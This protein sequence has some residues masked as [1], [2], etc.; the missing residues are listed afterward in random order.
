[1]RDSLKRYLSP[2][3]AAF[4]VFVLYVVLATAYS[5][6]N[7]IFESPDE[8]LHY[9]YVRTLIETR[10]LPVQQDGVQSEA[11][12]PPLYYVLNALVAGFIPV[13]DYQ[14]AANP[15]WAYDAYRVG[16]DNKNLYLH[17]DT[18][19]FPYHATSLAVHVMRW[20]S[21]ALG[22]L[23]L[24]VA[25]RLLKD[26]FVDRPIIV[27]GVL[28][29]ATFNPQFLFITSSINNDN[30]VT[31][32]GTLVLWWSVRS[33][34]S[35]LATRG[36]VIG[37][38]LLGA[39]LLTKLSAGALLLVML[40][41][42]V[43]APATWRERLKSVVVILLIA[44]L[45][46]GWWFVRNMQLY[47]EPTGV[48]TMLSIWGQRQVLPGF[49]ETQAQVLGLWQSFWGKFGYG[50]IVL[51]DLLYSVLALIGVA[52]LIGW[53]MVAFRQRRSNLNRRDGLVLLS[54]LLA[55]LI[56]LVVFG[57]SN[58]SG[59]HGRL[60][61][62][63]I[64]PIAVFLFLG[65]RY[66]LR[67]D[68]HRLDVLVAVVSAAS[69]LVLSIVALFTYLIPA[70]AKPELLDIAQVRDRTKPLHVRYG[71]QALL[72]GYH[73]NRNR[74]RVGDAFR[75]TLCWQALATTDTNYFQSVHLLRLEDETI[76]ARR[77]SYTGLG[78]FPSSQWSRGDV[79]CDMLRMPV[80]DWT[81]S[82]AVYD[83]RVGLTNYETRERLSSVSS[84]GQPLELVLVDRIKV[85]PREPIAVAIDAGVNATVDD[86]MRLLDAR[87][88]P[89][90]VSRGGTASLKLVWQALRVP[91]AD[92]TV[93][94]HV[95]DA[96]GTQVAQGDSQPLD[97]RYPTSFW[98]ADEVVIDTHRIEVP[99][100]LP[101]GA[102]DV[103]VGVYLLET[104]ERLPIED[105]LDAS[106]YVA[107]L[108]VQP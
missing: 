88:N 21:I 34:R 91:D 63:A 29:V 55:L 83:L 10:Q 20:L 49:E 61:F 40:V 80:E 68:A 67:S 9:E 69:L 60:L 106:V 108:T 101:P 59:I 74:V 52:S 72:L 7:P 16:D 62:P 92:Y 75:V 57:R 42:I 87:L 19:N 8:W 30:L 78:R 94:V 82:P 27:V 22:G 77:E 35:R 95:L 6:A 81:P 2:A 37:G 46:S 56:A 15:F 43:L 58:P 89:T 85:Q 64:V 1:M 41:A 70:Y 99:Q 73:I 104:L 90:S 45:L 36:A 103:N 25:Y 53:S 51:P 12:Q 93:F 98:D 39:A 100:S 107:T 11:H 26:V 44:A 79:F 65:L 5:V 24:Y 76:V 71:D 32:L 38:M 18:E 31:L 14:P 17:D 105:D 23:T 28:S 102:Y 3:R 84:D 47:N 48:E 13:D 54:A 66:F 97:G 96:D 86:Q 50:Q 33:A 4:V